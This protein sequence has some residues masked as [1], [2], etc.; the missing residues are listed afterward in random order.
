MDS[1]TCLTNSQVAN[2]NAG[3]WDAPLALRDLAVSNLHEKNYL[4]V[5][6]KIFQKQPKRKHKKKWK[7]YWEVLFTVFLLTLYDNFMQ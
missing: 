7:I 1:Q 3:W 6:D 2:H 5:L 4:V